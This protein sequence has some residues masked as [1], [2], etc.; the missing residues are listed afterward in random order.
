IL[1]NFYYDEEINEKN[2]EEYIQILKIGSKKKSGKGFGWGIDLCCLYPWSNWND[3]KKIKQIISDLKSINIKWV[4][5]GIS[6][7]NVIPLLHGNLTIAEV[8]NGMVDSLAKNISLGWHD[9]IIENLTSNNI[10]ILMVVGQGYKGSLPLIGNSSDRVSPDKIGRENYLGWIYLYVRAVVNK[11]CSKIRYWQI[12]NELNAAGPTA[13][14]FKWRTEELSWWDPFF[15]KKLIATLSDAVYKEG[16]RA[17]LK[18]YTVHNFH[19]DVPGWEICVRAWLPYLDV[20]GI[21]TYPNYLL[22]W[23]QVGWVVGLKVLFAKLLSDKRPVWVIETGFPTAPKERGFDENRQAKY[24]ESAAS[25]AY[26]FGASVFIWFTI[27]SSEVNQFPWYEPQAV[28]SY[29]GIIKPGANVTVYTKA[30]YAYES[31]INSLD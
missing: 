7:R 31:I 30:W 1:I 4:R 21:D 29:W 2:I 3:A 15:L 13:T 12:E 8:T 14:F 19:T 24:L 22:G 23:L 6:W 10:S 11:Y 5:I 27:T 16:K 28:E 17:G 9:A 20:I 18:L 25:S 26:N